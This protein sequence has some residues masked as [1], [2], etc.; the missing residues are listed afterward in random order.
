MIALRRRPFWI[1]LT[2]GD[3][4]EIFYLFTFIAILA[5]TYIEPSEP[6][7]IYEKETISLSPPSGG[8][9]R[10]NR[11]NVCKVK[12]VCLSPAKYISLS[13]SSPNRFLFL[14]I[15]SCKKVLINCEMDSDMSKWR[16]LLRDGDRFWKTSSCQ[17]LVTQRRNLPDVRLIL[18]SPQLPPTL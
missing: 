3:G 11:Q 7:F 18:V 5:Y 1:F 12:C 15:G 10:I 6:I 8:S 4:A 9:L 17:T 16:E 13:I 2:L 14:S